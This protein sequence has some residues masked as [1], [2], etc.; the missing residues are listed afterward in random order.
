MNYAKERI[1]KKK[2]AI[3]KK[4]NKKINNSTQYEQSVL[5]MEFISWLYYGYIKI[6]D[7]F[8]FKHT[9]TRQVISRHFRALLDATGWSSDH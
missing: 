9:P 2:E 6:P 4:N 1:A 5:L 7:T 8:V 3:E